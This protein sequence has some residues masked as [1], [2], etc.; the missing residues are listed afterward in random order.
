MKTYEMLENLLSSGKIYPKGKM[1][2][3][4]TVPAAVLK[5]VKAK[6]TCVRVKGVKAK[7]P[8]EPVALAD[9]KKILTAAKTKATKAK[10]IH[11]A[12]M[13]VVEELKTDDSAEVKKI[14]NDE[15][16]RSA[17]I[18]EGLLEGVAAAVKEVEE[19]EGE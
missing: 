7:K 3:E 12:N 13:K 6:A 4:D 10:T 14:A 17:A 18:L 16:E 15:A 1:Y 2:N 19:Y 5:E 11:T 9:L 8:T